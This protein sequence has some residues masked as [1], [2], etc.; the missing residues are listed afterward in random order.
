MQQ[1]I[2]GLLTVDLEDWFHT[3][4]KNIGQESW[5]EL[6]SLVVMHTD[7]LLDLFAQYNHHATFF[8]LGWVADHFPDLLCRIR[9]AG[10][11]IASHGY[12]H[13]WVWRLGPAGFRDDL[14]RSREAIERACGVTPRGYRAPSWSICPP[15]WKDEGDNFWP[16]RILQEEGFRYDASCFPAK[17]FRYGVADAPLLPHRLGLGKEPFYEL[18]AAV[19][20]LFGKRIPFAGGFYLRLYPLALTRLL[21]RLFL[22]RCGG[23]FMCYIHPREVSPIQPHIKVKLRDHIIRHYG[24]NS[25]R[26]K[27]EQL[28]RSF[29]FGT[30]QN[31]LE[32]PN[33][34]ALI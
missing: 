23:P 5:H 3:H 2:Q 32:L 19:L 31:Y 14:V 16:L 4:C 17:N 10:H 30:I 20:P 27:Y 1:Q 28:L 29:R 26:A 21:C 12:A 7:I 6:E 15:Q 9:D 33:Q 11:E 22:K 13:G 24:L 34:F 18:P 8:T 25:S